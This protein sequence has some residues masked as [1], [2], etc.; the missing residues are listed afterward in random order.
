MERG[1]RESPPSPSRSRSLGSSCNWRRNPAIE[2]QI[3]TTNIPLCCS[4]SS[5]STQTS[6][7]EGLS[8]SGLAHSWFCQASALSC[9]SLA[10]ICLKIF[11]YFPYTGHKLESKAR[12]CF[13]DYVPFIYRKR[14]KYKNTFPV[15]KGRRKPRHVMALPQADL[16][17]LVGRR[18]TAVIFHPLNCV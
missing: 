11:W 10:K 6:P 1:L 5:S 13:P 3:S 14:V 7:E 8:T 4:L 9:S 15:Q 2:T 12:K 16:K 17:S 18:L